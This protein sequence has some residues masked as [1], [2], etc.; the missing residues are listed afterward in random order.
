MKTEK[1]TAFINDLDLDLN[2]GILHLIL[3]SVDGIQNLAYQQF[4]VGS[5][6]SDETLIMIISEDLSLNQKQ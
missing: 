3:N 6:S 4:Q 5:N 1:H 2:D